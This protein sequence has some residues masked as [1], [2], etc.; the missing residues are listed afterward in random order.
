MGAA[1]LAH[2]LSSQLGTAPHGYV[3]FAAGLLLGLCL[4][5]WGLVIALGHAYQ[6]LNPIEDIPR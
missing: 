3:I 4:V 2:T 1:L 6:R 5:S